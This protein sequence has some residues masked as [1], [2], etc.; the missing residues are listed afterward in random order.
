[1]NKGVKM[2]KKVLGKYIIIDKQDNPKQY[3]NLTLRNCQ[4][5][6]LNNKKD[7]KLLHQIKLYL[8]IW[9]LSNKTK[10][11]YLIK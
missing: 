6:S 11:H 3:D 4:L 5:N 2:N 10:W 1:M 9:Y 7:S 8:I